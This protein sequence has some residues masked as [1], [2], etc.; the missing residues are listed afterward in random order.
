MPP[1]HG[2]TMVTVHA[3][4]R[5]VALRDADL[6]EVGVD[7]GTEAQALR[8]ARLAEAAGCHGVVACAHVVGMR[9]R[10]LGPQMLR[11]TPGIQWLGGLEQ[12]QA[13]GRG[14]D[15]ALDRLRAASPTKAC[16]AGATHIVIGR[17]ITQADDPRAAFD[18]VCPEALAAS[19]QLT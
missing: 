7:A 8:L 9:R 17:S 3:S 5:T 13:P 1:A 6:R 2:A 11:V 16:R 14:A 19:R 15:L 10:A 12:G 4:G 18:A